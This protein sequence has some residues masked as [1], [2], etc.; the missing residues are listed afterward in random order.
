[1][2]S[3]P[4]TYINRK[5]TIAFFLLLVIA[6]IAFTFNYSGIIKY[7]QE[8]EKEDPLGKRLLAL[9]EIMSNLQEADGAARTY[10]ITGI[11]KDLLLYQQTQDSAVKSLNKLKH[12]FADSSYLA[13]IDT[14]H[15]LLDKKKTQ[16]MAI[17]DL[18]NINRYRQRY[19]QL[20]PMLPDSISY[21][22]NQKTW[23]SIK[24]NSVDKSDNI[25]SPYEQRSFFGK[26][27]NFLSRK[28][29]E[30]PKQV[31][32]PEISQL[33]DSTSI[34]RIIQRPLNEVKQQ[35]EK[36]DKQDK[37]FAK[38]LAQ[39][40][41]SLVLL[42]NQLTN[43]I[44]G[45]VKK[46]EEQAIYDS[47]EH[48]R[49]LEELK[50]D[51]FKKIILLGISVFLIFL[52][53]VLWIGRDLRKSRR[54]REELISSREKIESLMKVKEKFLA[55]MSHE[56]R[57]PLTAIIGFS[58]IMKEENDSAKVI[59]NS[60]L[61]L[62]SLVNDILDYSTLQEGKLT[63]QKE[64]INAGEL[65]HEVYQ[66]FE[67]KA[68]QK[69]LD[70]SFVDNS[71]NL[72]FLEDK[73]R[74]KQI[75]FNLT[76]NAIKFTDHG[77]VWLDLKHKDHQLIFEVGDTGPGISP[78]KSLSVF[79]EFTRLNHSN[80]G[81]EGTGLGLAISKQLVQTMGGRIG[82]S[83][84]FGH[85]SLFWFTIPYTPGDS[86]YPDEKV[87]NIK[88]NSTRKVFIVDD[89]PMVAQLIRRFIGNSSE[90]KEYDSASNALKQ[91]T[92]ENPSLI[93]TDFRMPGMNGVEFIHKIREHRKIPVLLLSAAMNE[94]Q[95]LETIDKFDNVY[96]M[97]KPFSRKDLLD[98]IK[99][100]H[101]KEK[102]QPVRK[103]GIKDQNET[104]FD[105]SGVTSFTGEDKEFLIS[106]T[107]TFIQDTQDNINK[108]SKLISRRKHGE[109]ADQ[110]HKM[111]T[112]FR[113]FGIQKGSIILKGIEILGKD[114]GSTAELKRALKRL[115]KNWLIVKEELNKSVINL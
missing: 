104:L 8:S 80:H 42:S 13:Y 67:S 20:I 105:L 62:L 89:D 16:T 44:R 96:I 87:V 32:S 70:F 40:E 18:S 115:K 6:G 93:I 99:A 100:A 14:L 19:G 59:H 97:S 74:L 101:N 84:N 88:K 82:V 60:A 51:L 35:L 61:H 72:C 109:I 78:E 68:R 23:S 31:R 56:I 86:N 15:K 81:T 69:Q 76:G 114:P 7:L 1:M 38:V 58:E 34:T 107:T 112:G 98:K 75:L 48:Q 66:T 55:N 113:Q 3:S 108:L 57:T 10:R 36:I 83:S 17:F 28:E 71:R 39:R 9:N 65:L 110:A 52:G 30:K 85:G 91:M 64:Q 12:S 4:E 103:P 11:K 53:F 24:V 26:I 5:I 50:N 106:V 63:L 47:L 92:S 2:P 54:L 25:E 102:D 37:R 27:A 41:Q 43:T 90:I 33:V 73:T 111:Q 46:L 94:N 22:I 79:N 49:A 95:T 45:L 21:Q 29:E 77:K